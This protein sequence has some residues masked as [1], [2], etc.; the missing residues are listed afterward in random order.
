M[1]LCH[2]HTNSPRN[3]T[4]H[5]AVP[6]RNQLTV[7]LLKYVGA[8]SAGSACSSRFFAWQTCRR[9]AAQAVSGYPHYRD[10][11][12][13]IDTDAVAGSPRWVDDSGVSSEKH[14]PRCP[15]LRKVPTVKSFALWCAR[16]RVTVVAV[17]VVLIAALAGG[18]LTAGSAFTDATNIP[19]SESGTAYGLLAQQA[20]ATAV[21]A[22]SGTI[23]WHSD[24]TAIDSDGVRQV[25][26][27]MLVQV[28]QLPG[29]TAVDNPFTTPGSDH[30]DFS[31]NTAYATVTL[32]AGTDIDPI[33]SAAQSVRSDT[34][35]VET[36]GTAF[37]EPPAPS[38]GT[39]GIGLIAALI[40]LFLLFRSRWAA[41][42][43]ILIG[44]VGVGSSLLAVLLISHVLDLS[45]TSVTMAALIGL[46]V[47]I[48]YA[49]F[50][51]NR[52]RKAA[53]AGVPVSQAIAQAVDT[54]GRAVIF[55]GATVIVALLGM[56][57]VNL[58]LLTGMAQAAAFT[59]L[60]TVAAALTLLPALLALLGHRVLSR[61]QRTA[62]ATGVTA[63]AP[64][65][66]RAMRWAALVQRAPRR[67]AGA[68]LLL[69]VLLATPVL[70]MRIGD[71]DASSDPVGTPSH[72]YSALM[73]DGF[74][75]GVDAPLLLVAQTPDAAAAAAFTNLTGQL[76]TVAGVATVR[77]GAQNGPIATVTVIP[78]T[79][80]QTVETADLVHH[81]RDAVIPA[82]ESGTDLHV[83]VGGATATSIDLGDALMSK[84]PA[85]L[86][87]IAV[88]GF[89]L[90]AVAFRSVLVPL[91]GVISNLATIVVGMGVLTAI[92]QFGWGSELLGVGSGAP[93]Q[94][95]VPVIIVGVMFGLS[96][97]Y[98][99]FLAS[100]MKEEWDHTQ[101]NSRAVR[102]GMA[103]TTPVIVAAALIMLSVFASFGFS[104]ERIVSAIGIGL[105]IAVVVDAFILRLAVVPAVMHL[106]GR[107]NWS[108]PGWAQ[109]ITPNLSIEGSPE[110][111]RNHATAAVH[112]VR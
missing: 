71:A 8:R 11:G 40:I 83:Y 39:E 109:R 108:Y 77:T 63:Q 92:F 75:A 84:L 20:G 97:D 64:P 100:R 18:V 99:V 5:P 86:A 106:I 58:S 19:D 57:V 7:A 93:I 25:I 33:L 104:G 22:E 35:Q 112:A 42:L 59:V 73:A 95:L 21:S 68:G 65:A 38:H 4:P 87:L 12:T 94:Y 81:L 29:V 30:I 14:C 70:G 55:A 6:S 44:V 24:G 54:S 48:D 110:P 82:A 79:S 41:A 2:R 53:T 23:V 107:R 3:P 26:N 88:L 62:L 66:G 103:E 85:Y 56:F 111:S 34:L 90:L 46:G 98:Q 72:S 74:G 80:A 37:T 31:V 43:P 67:V 60:F 45:S 61:K 17:W 47:G 32:A 49:L 15:I 16:H 102:V 96:M 69:I 50:I 27:A 51:V 91:I 36:G 13:P 9:P 76:P 52:F 10:R 101:D 105:A 89:L 28:A 1:A 78:T